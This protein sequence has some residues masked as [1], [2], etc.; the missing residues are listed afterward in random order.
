MTDEKLRQII[1][2]QWEEG[3]HCVTLAI[4]NGSWSYA[5]FLSTNPDAKAKK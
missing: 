3:I 2:G 5:K 4:F 1:D